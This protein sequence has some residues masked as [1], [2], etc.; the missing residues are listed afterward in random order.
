MLRKRKY[1]LQSLIRACRKGNS[2]AQ[3]EL[4]CRYQKAMYNTALRI[5]GNTAEAED[6]M[7]EAFLDAFCK[8]DT[9]EGRASFGSWLKRI[10]IN[11]CL[12]QLKR[13]KFQWV[14]EE[15]TDIENIPEDVSALVDELPLTPD[16]ILNGIEQ[17][18][19]GFRIIVSLY[20]I[21]GYDHQ[22]IADILGIKSST[23]RSQYIRGKERL[24][25]IL[26]EKIKV[27]ESS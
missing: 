22:E 11:K 6:M 16:D 2:Q 5:M 10:V 12:N 20:L 3:M 14:D 23:S 24:R 21:E 19:D 27:S 26:L 8:L 4:Y 13:R 15:E 25:K 1:T 9:F 17:L 18:A 7:Q